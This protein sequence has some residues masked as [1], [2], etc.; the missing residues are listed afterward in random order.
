MATS[1]STS[2]STVLVAPTRAPITSPAVFI[3][4]SIE[5]G[6]AT[7]WQRDL[8]GSLLSTF[9]ST[10]GITILNPRR[11]DWD[12]SWPQDISCPQFAEQVE[13]EL[14]HLEKADIIAMY[15]QPDTMSPISLLELGMYATERG[16]KLV[17]CCPDG[18]WRRGNVQVVCA[19]YGVKL[20]EA[21]RE[22]R[23]EVEG[24][25]QRL[26]ESRERGE[27]GEA[28]KCEE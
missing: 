11:A 22:M 25:L 28:V 10:S 13:W 19:R 17:V 20:V 5:M 2:S 12:L 9:A 3:A 26:L 4:G 6:K 14:E 7:D 27:G 16:N 15:L 23:T 18:F 1:P 8:I 21:L 24:R